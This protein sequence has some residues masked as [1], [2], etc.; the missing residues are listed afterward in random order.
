MIERGSISVCNRVAKFAAFMNR[1]RSLRRY[2]T[3][4]STGKRGLLEETLQAF[5]VLRDVRINVAVCAF[6]ICIRYEAG[7]TVSRSGYVDG[8]E[9][10]LLDQAIQLYR[11]E[12]R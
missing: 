11:D 10:M 8:I 4:N 12:A 5:F 3:G 7:A 1:A 6:E 2:V 9:M